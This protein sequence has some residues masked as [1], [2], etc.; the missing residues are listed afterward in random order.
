MTTMTLY[1][2]PDSRPRVPLI[3]LEEIGHP[4]T[5]EVVALTVTAAK[6]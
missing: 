3:A 2:A 5:L 4:Y 6:S 1:F